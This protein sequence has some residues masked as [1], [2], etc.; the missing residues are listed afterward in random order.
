MER[1]GK[2]ELMEE[3]GATDVRSFKAHFPSE[4]PPPP[5]EDVVISKIKR[6]VVLWNKELHS[7]CSG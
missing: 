6:A 1:K 4:I 5:L 2:E 7:S 3:G